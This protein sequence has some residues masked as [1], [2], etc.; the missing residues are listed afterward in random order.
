MLRLRLLLQLQEGLAPCPGHSS[1][2][3]SGACFCSTQVADAGFRR[4]HRQWLGNRTSQQ[5][6]GLRLS[7]R[8]ASTPASGVCSGKTHDAHGCFL[9]A[10]DIKQTKTKCDESHTHASIVSVCSCSLKV[11]VLHAWFMF[12]S[13]LD[14]WFMCSSYTIQE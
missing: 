8:H 13:D 1:T 9:V 14:G 11:C 2:P 4:L 10:T 6:Q 3:A 5:Q 7:T 12:D